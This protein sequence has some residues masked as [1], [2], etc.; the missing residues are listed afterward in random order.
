MCRIR[1][2]RVQFPVGHGGFHATFVAIYCNSS[3]RCLPRRAPTL[4]TVVY[5]CGTQTSQSLL[6]Q[7][8]HQFWQMRDAFRARYRIR[9]ERDLIVLSHIDADHVSGVSSLLGYYSRNGLEPLVVLPFLPA[10]DALTKI[11]DAHNRGNDLY[12][13][14]LGLATDPLSTLQA[15]M[16]EGE[17]NLPESNVVVVPWS[18]TE[19][20]SE[21]V[22]YDPIGQ[23]GFYGSTA[24]PVEFSVDREALWVVR[25]QL[26]KPVRQKQ[27][28][29]EQALVN[30]CHF[31]RN[32][33]RSQLDKPH[34]HAF[35]RFVEQHISCIRSA[36]KAA[37]SAGT[38]AT[39]LVAYSGPGV[40]TLERSTDLWHVREPFCS[41]AGWVAAR[42]YWNCSGGPGGWLHTGD[43]PLHERAVFEEIQTF[44]TAQWGLISTL[45][46]PHHGSAN[47]FNSDLL[48]APKLRRVVAAVDSQG[49]WRFPAASV[50]DHIAAKGRIALDIV[51][52]CDCT[53]VA[54][55]LDI[56]LAR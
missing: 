39:S 4:L 23:T 36:T 46:L 22:E 7:R 27:A 38:N 26:P 24:P 13:T 43:A 29:F 18:E 20:T 21:S 10:L 19:V 51:D 30:A 16:G 54:E 2:Q 17:G 35:R 52:R 25:L 11:A 49:R 40:R 28:K 15:M 33:L 31:D 32:T 14:V 3:A 53:A 45:M 42:E 44:F 6:K 41:F 47:G 55:D 50:C 5:D 1:A 8:I 56:V 37:S 48:T 12:N 34:G 9:H